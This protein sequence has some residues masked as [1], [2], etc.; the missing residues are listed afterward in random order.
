VNADRSASSMN[1]S[2]SDTDAEAKVR[3]MCFSFVVM[4]LSCFVFF[5]ISFLA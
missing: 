1:L 4:F 2:P 5:Y 3:T